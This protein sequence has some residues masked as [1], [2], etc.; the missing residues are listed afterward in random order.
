MNKSISNAGCSSCRYYLQTVSEC[1]K[2]NRRGELMRD[3]LIGQCSEFKEI[4]A[5]PT[6]KESA[7]DG[8][9]TPH[10]RE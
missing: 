10:L 8:Y 2:E 4:Q 3:G 7:L 9:L 6:R 5:Y 1:L